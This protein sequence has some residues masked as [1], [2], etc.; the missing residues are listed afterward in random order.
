[1]LNR[2]H[3]TTLLG[4]GWPLATPKLKGLTRQRGGV[5]CAC[6]P[7]VTHGANAAASAARCQSRRDHGWLG[8]MDIRR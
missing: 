7:V 3:S 4:C 6:T 2:V 1:M 5:L 8:V